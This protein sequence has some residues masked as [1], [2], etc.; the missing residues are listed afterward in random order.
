[1][2]RD[3]RRWKH[4]GVEQPWDVGEAIG[5]AWRG[6]RHAAL[7]L[8]LGYL[9]MLLVSPGLTLATR[10][11]LPKLLRAPWRTPSIY[12]THIT[13][14]ILA[15]PVTAA[16]TTWLLRAA[17][18]AA[19]GEP[20]KLEIGGAKETLRIFAWSV[21]YL[22]L[23]IVTIP[24]F[25][26]P[27]LGIAIAPFYIVDKGMPLGAALR[28]SWRATRGHKGALWLYNLAGLPIFFLGLTAGGVGICRW[29][30]PASRSR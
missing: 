26:I 8:F 28:A 14:S 16:L 19:R 29:P 9:V 22:V 25:S 1:M 2:N 12:F 6:L 30:W 4:E 18:A 3:E 20:V 15:I 10:Y 13:V 27:A 5:V 21:L 7:R 23:A 24:A 17:L 11:G